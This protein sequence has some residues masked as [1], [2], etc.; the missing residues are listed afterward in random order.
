[1]ELASP[2]D[3]EEIALLSR[4]QV[5]RG[6]PWRY[7]PRAVR[8]MLANPDVRVAVVRE[9][10]RIAAFGVMSFGANEAHLVLLAVRPEHRR[11]GLAREIVAWLEAIAL[12]AGIELFFVECRAENHGAR[13]LYASLGYRELAVTRGYYGGVED[14]V[15]L[16]K[17]VAALP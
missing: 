2:D 8:A 6:L 3:A 13:A 12:A 5:E 4:D 15:R 1:M 17:D 10:G 7:H 9:G 11:R 16:G 14:A